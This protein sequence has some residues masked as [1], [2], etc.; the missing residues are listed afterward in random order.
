MPALPDDP[1]DA[2]FQLGI[3]AAHEVGHERR[4]LVRFMAGLVAGLSDLGGGEETKQLREVHGAL[5][6]LTAMGYRRVIMS[7]ADMDAFEHQ[8]GALL[9]STYREYAR[10]QRNAGPAN[11]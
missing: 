10:Q 5:V 3:E 6:T 9:T 4:L 2:C 1:M 8:L 11:K 7:R